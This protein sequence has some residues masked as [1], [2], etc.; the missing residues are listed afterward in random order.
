MSSLSLSNLLVPTIKGATVYLVRVLLESDSRMRRFCDFTFLFSSDILFIAHISKG[1][2]CFSN[3]YGSIIYQLSPFR[4]TV[5][6]ENI[7]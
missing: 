3:A 1:P 6:V 2:K 4:S 7:F 5:V